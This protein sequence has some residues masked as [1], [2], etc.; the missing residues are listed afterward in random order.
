MIRD[1]V[2]RIIS[3]YYYTIETFPDTYIQDMSLEAFG[4]GE[5][6]HREANAQARRIAGLPRESHKQLDQESLF[7]RAVYNIE[8]HF[9]C[10]GL[11]C[12][13]DASLIAMRHL[14]NWRLYQFYLREKST[15]S[16]PRKEAIPK[17]TREAIAA[18]NRADQRLYDYA[19]DRLERQIDAIGPDFK[20]DLSRFEIVNRLYQILAPPF[21]R[22]YRHVS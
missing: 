5:S 3:S 19:Q 11:L 13:F 7:E 12:R 8:Q 1:P 9:A 16:R 6:I 2:D 20:K 18:A 4:R 14:L 22:L 21:A 10:V 17:S 15:S